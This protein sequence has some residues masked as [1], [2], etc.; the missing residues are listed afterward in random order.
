[1]HTDKFVMKAFEQHHI[2][3]I[4]YFYRSIAEINVALAKIHKSIE[5]KLDKGKYR[6]LTDYID[7][8]ISHTSVWNVKFVVNL[9]NPEVAM[10]QIF[11]L[12]YIFDH[13]EMEHF[14]FE[15][16]ILAQLEEKFLELNAFKQEHI[17]LR[18]QKLLNKIATHENQTDY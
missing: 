3:Q 6:L 10:L 7:Q 12:E 4:R 11:H 8:Y 14:K 17:Q 15:R 2:N 18:K 13:E 9:E 1:M 5:C 16:A